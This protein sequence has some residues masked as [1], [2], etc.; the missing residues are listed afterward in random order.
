M[1]RSTNVIEKEA[2]NSLFVT[3][4]AHAKEFNED[5]VVYETIVSNMYQIVKGT[6]DETRLYEEGYLSEYSSTILSPIVQKMTEET[7][8]SAGLYI[9]FDPRYTGRSEGIWA[10]VDENG[11]LIHSIPTNVAGKSQDDPTASFYYDAIKAGKAL[12][13]D[14][15]VNNV[16]V[17]V[18]SYSMPIITIHLLE[19]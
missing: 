1:I 14:F 13:G 5:L 16:N 7:E 11:K 2:K 6:I 9:V 3:G 18:M 10:A 19:Q 12:W 15:Y 4:E 17:N 8:K